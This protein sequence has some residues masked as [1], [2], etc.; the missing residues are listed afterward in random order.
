MR[1]VIYYVVFAFV[2]CWVVFKYLSSRKNDREISIM[3]LFFAFCSLLLKLWAPGLAKAVSALLK[4][5]GTDIMNV[6]FWDVAMI[7]L[8]W[9]PFLSLNKKKEKNKK[10]SGSKK[11]KN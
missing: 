11:N 9:F 5:D 6:F 8:L 3:A 4:A 10:G 2:I 7:L 1:D